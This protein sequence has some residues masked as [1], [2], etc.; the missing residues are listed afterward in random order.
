[1]MNTKQARLALVITALSALFSFP[2]RADH[3]F[4][5]QDLYDQC[6]AQRK[7]VQ[8][9]GLTDAERIQA[10]FCPAYLLGYSDAGNGR[11]VG[12]FCYPLGNMPN[13][14]ELVRMFMAWAEKN[15][16]WVRKKSAKDCAYDAF[17]ATYACPPLP[18]PQ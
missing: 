3:F 17:M 8:E 1:M 14:D 9:G 4:T 18:I 11:V 5:C 15:S 12:G 16:F 2:A 13:S 6:L 10:T 7:F